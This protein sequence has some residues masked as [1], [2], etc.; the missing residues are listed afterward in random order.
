VLISTFTANPKATAISKAVAS[1]SAVNRNVEVSDDINAS[2]VEFS[3][4]SFHAE[5]PTLAVI[6][7][8]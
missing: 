8:R 5:Q 6:L 3:A 7:C 2:L 1:G 4:I